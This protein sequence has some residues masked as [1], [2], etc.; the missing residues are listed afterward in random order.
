[1]RDYC[2]KDYEKN[3]NKHNEARYARRQAERKKIRALLIELKSVPCADCHKTYKPWQM[4]FDHVR[5]KKKFN[6]SESIRIASIP[7]LEVEI[8]K[9]EVVCANCHAD[10]TYR[11]NNNGV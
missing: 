6:I 11:R 7:L 10:R 5:G 1:M 8:R 2:R 4:Q 3:K 9:C